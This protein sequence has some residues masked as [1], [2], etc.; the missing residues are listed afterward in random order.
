MQWIID[1]K[2]WIFSGVGIFIIPLVIGI[3]VKKQSS[4]KQIQ[5]SGSKSTNYQ[6][7]GDINIGKK[8]D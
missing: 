5:K 8:D 3:F 6:A 4:S 1:N 2:D 7:G